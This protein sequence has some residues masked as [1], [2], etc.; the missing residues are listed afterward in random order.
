MMGG[1]KFED[2]HVNLALGR[3][4]GGSGRQPGS[5]FKAFALAEAVREGYSVKSVF[6][7]PSSIEIP[8]RHRDRRAL[9]R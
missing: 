1:T 7:S 3:D 4:G 2:S 8:E 9:A 6:S 5:T